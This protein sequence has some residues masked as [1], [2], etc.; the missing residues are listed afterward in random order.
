[1]KQ[2]HD[3]LFYVSTQLKYEFV[4]TEKNGRKRTLPV[5]SEQKFVLNKLSLLD[6]KAT[7]V[8]GAQF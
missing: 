2:H 7:Q 6:Y 4:E 3:N 5:I 8:E 1:M